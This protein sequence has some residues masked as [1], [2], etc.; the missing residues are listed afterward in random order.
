MT[1][2]TKMHGVLTA[3]TAREYERQA[4]DGQ[5]YAA[6]GAAFES[7]RKRE[8]IAQFVDRAHH[9]A[10]TILHNPQHY[11]AH[12]VDMAFGLIDE[13]T[14]YVQIEMKGHR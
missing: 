3:R 8:A 1:H 7:Q 14:R 13:L 2:K 6:L 12:A 11:S 10:S 4:N 5:L 9:L